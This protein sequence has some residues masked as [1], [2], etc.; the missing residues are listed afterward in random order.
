MENHLQ[1]LTIEYAE[2]HGWLGRLLEWRGSRNAPDC[3]FLKEGRVILIEFKIPD[4]EP[5]I[6]Q[7][8][9]IK[10]LREYGAEVYVVDNLRD[11]YAI[12]DAN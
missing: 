6:G 12:F 1:T 8:R 10:K 7:T 4:K 3:F 9:E 11:A 2:K 5:R